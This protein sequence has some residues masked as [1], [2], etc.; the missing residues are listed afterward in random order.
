MEIKIKIEAVRQRIAELKSKLD[1][2]NDTKEKTR[3]RKTL[4]ALKT[5]LTEM[6][7][8]IPKRRDYVVRTKFVFEGSFRVYATSKDEALKIVREDCGMRCGEI[9][10]SV[11]N[12]L[13]WDFDMTPVKI[14][15]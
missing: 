10:A 13:D 4:R 3:I 14:A 11:P 9:H 12:V 7:G 8:F 6:Q 5:K 1:S 15:K 2:C